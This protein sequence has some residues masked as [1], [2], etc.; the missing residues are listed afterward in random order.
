MANKVD[1]FIFLSENRKLSQDKTFLQEI[2]ILDK[3]YFLP[4]EDVSIMYAKRPIFA[5]NEHKRSSKNIV[6]EKAQS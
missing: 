5:K 4:F 1:V 2:E 3:Y 6:Q